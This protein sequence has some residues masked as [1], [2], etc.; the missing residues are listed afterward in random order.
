MRNRQEAIGYLSEVCTEIF[1]EQLDGWYR[2]PSSWPRECDVNTFL[3]WFEWTLHSMVVDLDDS[4]I[5]Y[6]EI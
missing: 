6:E 5:E 1:E 3:N 2:V 4:P